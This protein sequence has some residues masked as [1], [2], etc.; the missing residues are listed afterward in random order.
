MKEK[1]FIS[2]RQRP[3]ELWALH[4]KMVLIRR[5]EEGT[6]KQYQQK[7][8]AGFLHTYIGTEGVGV[9][10]LA[11]KQPDDS[12]IRMYGRSIHNI[13]YTYEYIIILSNTCASNNSVC[14]RSL[15]VFA[16]YHS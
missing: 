2:I 7:K 11:H 15:H 12:S 6:I 10:L 4:K 8:I 13:I 16:N 3:E 5:F 14:V 1:K 9:G